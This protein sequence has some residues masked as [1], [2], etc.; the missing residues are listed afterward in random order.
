MGHWCRRRAGCHA[1]GLL[2]ARQRHRLCARS[3]GDRGDLLGF[4]VAD[5]RVR[6]IAVESSVA[7]AFVL[8]AAAAITGTPWLL[9]A[10]FVGHGLKDLW[11]HRTRFVATRGGGRRSAWP[12][13]GSWP[14]SSWSR[15]PPVFASAERP[16]RSTGGVWFSRAPRRLFRWAGRLLLRGDGDRR[17]RRLRRLRRHRLAHV[18]RLPSP[19]ISGSTPSSS[20]AGRPARRAGRPPRDR[21]EGRPGARRSSD[22]LPRC[23]GPDMP[24]SIRRQCVRV[25]SSV[26]GQNP[27]RGTACQS[28]RLSQDRGIPNRL[29]SGYTSTKSERRTSSTSVA[30]HHRVVNAWCCS[31]ASRHTLN[32]SSGQPNGSSVR[33]A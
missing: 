30:I 16:A 28:S 29:S 15:S 26:A 19:A 3:G 12:S 24:G 10:G 18:A 14:R 1:A 32:R 20:P 4:A 8:V 22:L 5:G 25:I 7:F 33:R 6:V 9:V 31:Q 23:R 27:V 17:L 21:G 2:V 11:Q 13:T